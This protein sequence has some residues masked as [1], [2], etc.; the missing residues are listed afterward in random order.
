MLSDLLVDPHTL[1][2]LAAPTSGGKFD[3]VWQ[4]RYGE[5]KVESVELTG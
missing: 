3:R 4:D 1:V 5:I 2:M